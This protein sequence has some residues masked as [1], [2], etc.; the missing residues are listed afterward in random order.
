MC[1]NRTQKMSL[2]LLAQPPEDGRRFGL[3]NTEIPA[4]AVQPSQPGA[5]CTDH[6]TPDRPLLKPTALLYLRALSHID[7]LAV[8]KRWVRPP[9]GEVFLPAPLDRR[10]LGSLR[11]GPARPSRPSSASCASQQ[12]PAG[13]SPPLR[14]ARLPTAQV[15]ICCRIAERLIEM[16]WNR[17]EEL[18]SRM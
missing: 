3:I 11:L 2:A 1:P 15:N 16:T 9:L 10:R 8:V 14:I 18:W 13:F 17:M 4:S 7:S 12:Q 6:P 5:T